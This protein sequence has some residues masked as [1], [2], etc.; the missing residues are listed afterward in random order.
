MAIAVYPPP[1]PRKNRDKT[2]YVMGAVVALTMLGL[3]AYAVWAIVSG[4]LPLP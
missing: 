2:D 1:G 4:S 3:I